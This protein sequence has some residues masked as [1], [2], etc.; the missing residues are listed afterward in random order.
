MTNHVP[1][2]AHE[3]H[4]ISTPAKDADL[5][6]EK[7]RRI[8]AGA[9]RVFF[10]K[11]FHRTTIREIALACGMSMGQLY[12]YI[13]SKDDVLYLVYQDM[14]E[15][16]LEHLTAS[17]V[18]DIDDPVR[19][20]KEALRSTLEFMVGHQE[21]FLFVY[22]ETKYL[23]GP[24]LHEVLEM[25]DKNVVGFW[26]RMVAGV[27]PEREGEVDFVANLISFLMVFPVLRGWNLEPGQM[28]RHLDRLVEFIVKGAGVDD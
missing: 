4:L 27:V 15:Q 10:E 22:T 24:H 8:V 28:D 23:A 5:V 11:G 20:L 14:Q 25:D 3:K 6:V 9:C 16:W 13:S 7:H 2:P 19:K 17:R 1:T 21:L 26:R 12:H 18:E